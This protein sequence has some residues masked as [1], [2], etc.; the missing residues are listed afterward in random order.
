MAQTLI[1]AFFTS[2]LDWKG[3]DAM[4]TLDRP[5]VLTHTTPWQ[6]VTPVSHPPLL[7]PHEVLQNPPPQT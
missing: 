1:H 2:R 5:Q 3:V 7:G 6:R 4:E